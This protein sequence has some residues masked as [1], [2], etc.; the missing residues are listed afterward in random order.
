M[1]Y[2]KPLWDEVTKLDHVE[3]VMFTSYLLA[4]LDAQNP[5]TLQAVV[6]LIN[7]LRPGYE[8]LLD[9]A[10]KS[11]A[12]TPDE[13]LEDDT[14]IF[15]HPTLPEPVTSRPSRLEMLDPEET[16]QTL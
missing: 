15:I 6:E 8:D 2:Y 7:A 3:L 14:L 16:T 1:N 11:G 13:A 4:Q 9:E 5:L 10:I 12:V